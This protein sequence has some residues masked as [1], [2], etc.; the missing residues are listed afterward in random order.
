MFYG[1]Y[2]SN[3]KQKECHCQAKAINIFFKLQYGLD[4]IQRNWHS[5][6]FQCMLGKEGGSFPSSTL[7]D[8]KETMDKLGIVS[9]HRQNAQFREREET[10]K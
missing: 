4:W 9:T 6:V 1:I 8:V 5:S 10:E 7:P 3:E 2:I